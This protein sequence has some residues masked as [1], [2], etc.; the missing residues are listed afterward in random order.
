MIP[1]AISG[2]I[3]GL[4]LSVGVALSLPVECMLGDT[5]DGELGW[6]RALSSA[7]YGLGE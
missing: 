4:S 7:W 5:L 1:E 2:S 6:L 3:S